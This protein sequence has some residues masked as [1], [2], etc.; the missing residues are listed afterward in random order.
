MN[1]RLPIIRQTRH[2]AA[3]R[4]HSSYFG[5][6]VFLVGCV[7]CAFNFFFR[8]CCFEFWYWFV[9]VAIFFEYNFVRAISMASSLFSWVCLVS[10]WSIYLQILLFVFIFDLTVLLKLLGWLFGTWCLS[11]LGF[12]QTF[13]SFWSMGSTV[14]FWVL[15]YFIE[16]SCVAGHFLWDQNCVNGILSC[17]VSFGNFVVFDS[18]FFRTGFDFKILC[19]ALNDCLNLDIF[20]L[21]VSSDLF[22]LLGLL[23]V[24][25]FWP[26]PLESIFPWPNLF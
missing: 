23:I 18:T 7:I 3:G 11:F 5:T 10:W 4:I 13:S 16:F 1:S 8:I 17:C 21:G 6:I 15:F 12:L 9:F 22:S 25:C 19:E 2:W 20:V 24:Y 14:P 26:V